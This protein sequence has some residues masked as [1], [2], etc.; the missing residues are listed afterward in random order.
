MGQTEGEVTIGGIFLDWVQNW[1][2]LRRKRRKK[3][4]KNINPTVI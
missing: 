1:G 4:K 2:R 3:A